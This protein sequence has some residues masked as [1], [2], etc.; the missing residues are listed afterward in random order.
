MTVFLRGLYQSFSSGI[1][2]VG[3]LEAAITI[4]LKLVQDGGLYPITHPPQKIWS[5]IWHLVSQLLPE[6]PTC[7]FG[8]TVHDGGP[9]PISDPYEFWGYITTMLNANCVA[10]K[11]QCVLLHHDVFCA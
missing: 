8:Q 5:N 11:T 7:S 2:L 1:S 9:R 4:N 3:H 10:R 6:I